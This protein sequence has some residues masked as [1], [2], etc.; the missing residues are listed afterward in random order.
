MIRNAP[1]LN[2]ARTRRRFLSAC[3]SIG[4]WLPV[5]IGVGYLVLLLARMGPTLDAI[6]TNGDVASAPYIGELYPHAPPGATLT[7]GQY[8]WYSTLWF[9]LATRQ[10]PFHRTL[11][12]VG[13]WLFSLLGIALLGWS[14]ARVAGRWAGVLVATVLAC[15][16]SALL[17]IQVSGAFHGAAVVHACILDTFLVLLVIGGGSIGGRFAHA[18]VSVAVAALTAVGLATD[19]VLYPAGVVPFAVAGIALVFL[20]PRRIGLR[21]AITTAAVA[22]LAVAGAQVVTAAMD[23]RRIVPGPFPITFASWGGLASNVG[24]LVQSI[25]KLFGGDLNGSEPGFRSSLAFACALAVAAALWALIRIG[26]AALAELTRATHELPPSDA[27]RFVHVTFWVLA[28]ALSSAAFIFSSA[29]ESNGGR[30]VLAAAYATVTLVAIAVAQRGAFARAAFV[31][32]ASLVVGASVASLAY[33]DLDGNPPPIQSDAFAAR[34]ASFAESEGLSV[35]Y[36]D[37]WDAAPLIWKMHERVQIYPVWACD[38]DPR[39]GICAVDLLKIDSWYVPRP[40]T[41][42]FLVLDTRFGPSDPYQTLGQPQEVVKIDTRFTIEV[43]DHDI[44]R[45]IGPP[46]L[47]G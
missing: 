15:A 45:N 10:I 25:A 2:L 6:Y 9:E 20:T 44:A 26:R 27:L 29:A 7:L 28:A 35:G 8:P 23:A 11:W 37:F 36:A 5:V 30:Y 21:I 16:G 1:A 42:T 41:R 43:F 47:H 40:D 24:N 38:P 46:A 19:K 18:G 22:A 12:E 31:A 14:T 39:D 3:A 13:P 17:P 34:L 4:R 32:G 33:R